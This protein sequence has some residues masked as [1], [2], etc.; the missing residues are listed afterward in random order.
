MKNNTSTP[1]T[2]SKMFEKSLLSCLF[3]DN[4]KE[5][6][7]IDVKINDFYDSTYRNIYQAI[8]NACIKDGEPFDVNIIITE[9]KKIDENRDWIVDISELMDFTPNSFNTKLY[10]EK[11]KELSAERQRLSL[12]DDFKTKKIGTNEFIEKFTKIGEEEKEEPIKLFDKSIIFAKPEPLKFIFKGLRE[13]TVGIFAGTGGSGKSYMSLAF[14][15]S[16]ADNSKRINYLNLF[17]ENRGK[18]GYVSLEDDEELIHHRLYNLQKFFEIKKNDKLINN[19]DILCLY[20]HNFRLAE[21]NFNKIEINKKAEKL[22]YDFC[23]GK[24][25]VVIDTLRRMS[26][27]NEN[28]SS[29]MSHVLRTIEKI[30]YDTGCSILINAHV[31]KTETEEGKNKV[32]GSG[33]ITDDTRFTLLLAKKFVKNKEGKINKK[34]LFLCWEKVNAIKIPEPIQLKWQEWIDKETLDTYSMIIENENNINENEVSKPCVGIAGRPRRAG[35]AG[36]L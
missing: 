10:A 26:N 15:L 32:R 24:K 25:F 27:L 19:F 36:E 11:I 21:K 22:L 3:V 1:I 7:E 12:I 18:C 2:N 28:D 13:G 4:G 8:V 23:N 14:L 30:S 31:N 34:E 17:N 9:L 29:E 20:G 33:S 16:Y 35:R 6:N 5:L